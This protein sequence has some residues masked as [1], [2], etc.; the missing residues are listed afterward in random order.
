[1]RAIAPV[2]Q[3]GP[4]PL[5]YDLHEP[6]KPV[7]DKQTAPILFLHGLFGSKKNN[8]TIILARD[9]GRYVFALDL[10]NHGGSPHAPRHDYTA[11]AED[12][13]AFI[14]E[15]GLKKPTLIGHS[16]G[17]KTAMALALRSPDT[18]NDLV[19]V[20]N[21]PID[22]TLGSDFGRY[23]QGMRK[24]DDA[25]VTRQA[26]A[27]E[28]LRPYEE[29]V[30]IRQFLL[31]NLHRPEG[32]KS[33]KFRVPLNILAKT[34]DNL[35]DFPYKDPSQVRFEKRALFIRGTH[36]K[37]VPDEVLPVIGQFFPRFELADIEAGHWLISEK[38]EAFREAVVRFLSPRDD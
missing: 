4:V 34:L 24:I 29:S 19:A 20:D 13:A 21:A 26:E 25:E 30:A 38:P 28:I 36:S 3:R 7:T 6:A 9:L 27:D 23:I 8:R 1:M 22:A 17:A 33:Q 35:G 2:L 15:H 18:V 32:S 31:G 14:Q 16:M 10:R 12:L 11:M 5:V 37:Y